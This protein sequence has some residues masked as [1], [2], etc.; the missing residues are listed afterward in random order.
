M[1]VHC[2]DC[3][4]ELVNGQHI[5]YWNGCNEEGE[6]YG[7]VKVVCPCGFEIEDSKWG[8]WEDYDDV[9]EFLFAELS[10]YLYNDELGN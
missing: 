6:D 4:S 9:S 10:K 1:N 7:V 5:D 2:P 3:G 8:E